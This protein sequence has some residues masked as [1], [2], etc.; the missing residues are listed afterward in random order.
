MA[1]PSREARRHVRVHLLLR[2]LT[3]IHSM[4]RPSFTQQNTQQ[5]SSF[6]LHYI[7]IT[8]RSQTRCE[9]QRYLCTFR[10]HSSLEYE[11]AI[12][13]EIT[14]LPARSYDK[15]NSP[16]TAEDGDGNLSL[17][18]HVSGQTR[19]FMTKIIARSRQGFLPLVFVSLPLIT[20]RIP[21]V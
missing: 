7:S 14:I 19:M 9:Q 5:R 4:P 21:H 2:A 20:L 8:N 10:P 17:L 15:L 18:T 1:E 12:P 16:Y 6:C 11:A 3:H 13:V